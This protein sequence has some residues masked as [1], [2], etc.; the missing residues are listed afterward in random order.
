MKTSESKAIN[1]SKSVSITKRKLLDNKKQNNV[2]HTIQILNVTKFVQTK[3]SA[4]NSV[5]T[6]TEIKQVD[7]KVTVVNIVYKTIQAT[8]TQT[9]V[10]AEILCHP[11][12][13]LKLLWR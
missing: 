3:K 6:R 4:N 5:T 13:F 8:E 1:E 12:G 2:R 9:K 11:F 10:F 7:H